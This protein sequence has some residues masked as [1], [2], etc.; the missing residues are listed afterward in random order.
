MAPLYSGTG[1]V[2]SVS[3]GG[4]GMVQSGSLVGN[5]FVDPLLFE[6]R[7]GQS[8]FSGGNCQA[9]VAHL[10]GSTPQAGGGVPFQPEWLSS[11]GLGETVKNNNPFMF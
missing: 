6:Q 4:V 5:P 7:M 11:S 2:Q 9:G 1:I 10:R 3:V 8:S